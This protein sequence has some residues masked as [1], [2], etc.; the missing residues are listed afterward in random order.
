M[1]MGR[2]LLVIKIVISVYK[3][4]SIMN[5]HA[6]WFDIV[7]LVDEVCARGRTPDQALF[8]TVLLC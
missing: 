3:S 1:L 2:V 8:L 4:I 7:A 5:Y 6:M